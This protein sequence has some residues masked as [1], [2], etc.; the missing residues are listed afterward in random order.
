MNTIGTTLTARMTDNQG[1]TGA[2]RILVAEPVPGPIEFLVDTSEYYMVV[3]DVASKFNWIEF[4]F[5]FYQANTFFTVAAMG[6]LI[7][8]IAFDVYLGGLLWFEYK[9]DELYLSSDNRFGG[10]NSGNNF[11]F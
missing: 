6:C 4:G 9:R 1:N 5:R 2:V 7:A 10:G 11:G 3:F 8:A